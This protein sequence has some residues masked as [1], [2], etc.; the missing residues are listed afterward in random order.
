MDRHERAPDRVVAVM[1]TAGDVVGEEKLRR[2]LEHDGMTTENAKNAIAQAMVENKIRWV[3]FR[4]YA[5][6]GRP[7][8]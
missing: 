2:L 1:R 3:A 6:G 8:V 4:G 7:H 5:I